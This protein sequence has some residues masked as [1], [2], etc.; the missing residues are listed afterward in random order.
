MELRRDIIGEDVYQ[1][2]MASLS[3][4][5]QGNLVARWSLDFIRDAL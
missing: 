3:G 1:A 4:V 5:A 2:G